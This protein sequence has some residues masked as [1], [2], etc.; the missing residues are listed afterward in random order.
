MATRLRTIVAS[1]YN[2]Q[3]ALYNALPFEFSNVIARMEGTRVLAPERRQRP[4]P[5]DLAAT[6]W[7]KARH[8]LGLGRSTQLVPITVEEDCDLFFYVC[9]NASHLA[10][11]KAI[12]GWR[13]RSRKAAAFVFETWSSHLPSNRA[14]L[15]LLNEFDHVFLFNKASVTNV[16]AYTTTPCRFLPAGTDTLLATPFPNNLSRLID[17]YSMGRRSDPTHRQLLE[18]AAHKEIFYIFDVGTG[19]EV[20]DFWQ[21]R[22]VTLNYIKRSRYFIAYDLKVGPK[23]LESSGEEA[24]PARFFEGAA[25]GAVM[26][27][28]KPKCP[29]FDD[30]FDWPDALI[31]I[32]VEPSDMRRILAELNRDPDRLAVASFRNAYESLRRHDWSYRWRDIL[33]ILGFEASEGVKARIAELN[34]LAD[35][36]ERSHSRLVCADARETFPARHA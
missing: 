17:V 9:M 14:E 2:G 4:V 36:A 23:A 6:T 16:Q 27:G 22:F 30:L 19:L 21:A 18:M 32:P 26:L 29:E 25:G 35:S 3:K 28:T 11:L 31:E 15:H 24:V 12:R 5:F 1:N 10:D 7:S 34:S 13:E 8:R 33:Q 20:Y